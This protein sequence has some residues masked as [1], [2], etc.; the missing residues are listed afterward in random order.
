MKFQKIVECL[1]DIQLYNTNTRIIP[2]PNLSQLV[3]KFNSD[4]FMYW[5]WINT[6][7]C[8]HN[9]LWLINRNPMSVSIDQVD[10]FKR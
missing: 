1:M 8:K 5:G 9:A 10:E 3:D 7:N 6:T 2:P 4:Y